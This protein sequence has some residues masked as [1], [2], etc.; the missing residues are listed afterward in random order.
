M[1]Q[2]PHELIRQVKIRTRAAAGLPD[3]DPS[4]PSLP[5]LPPLSATIATADDT[6]PPDLRCRNCKALLLRGSES[7]VCLYCGLGPHYDAVPDPI[8]F[9]S[10]V[11]Y[12]WLLRSLRLDGSVCFFYE[13][14]SSNFYC[15]T[16][17]KFIL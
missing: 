11:G 2:F 3:Y 7:I 6:S 4:D 12:Q 16:E 14:S 10:T 1:A 13:S 17:P 5:A 8:C 15:S 9:T